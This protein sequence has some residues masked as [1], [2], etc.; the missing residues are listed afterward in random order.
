MKGFE[1]VK[2]LLFGMSW[3]EKD[4]DRGF[5]IEVVDSDV[6]FIEAYNAG[7]RE[8]FRGV[9]VGTEARTASESCERRRSIV[10]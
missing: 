1:R 9:G 6:G 7:R 8:G 10:W 3:K 4:V 5:G 2:E